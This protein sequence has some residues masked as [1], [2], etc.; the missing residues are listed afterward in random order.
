MQAL[1]GHVPFGVISVLMLAAIGIFIWLSVRMYNKAKSQK[2]DSDK[3]KAKEFGLT[4]ALLAGMLSLL[5]IIACIRHWHITQF[6]Q[7]MI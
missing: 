2:N 7:N 1:L 3:T 6:L 5:F 4:F